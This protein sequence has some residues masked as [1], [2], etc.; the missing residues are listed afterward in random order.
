MYRNVDGQKIVKMKRSDGSS[1]RL[2]LPKK[3]SDESRVDYQDWDALNGAEKNH[4][5]NCITNFAYFFQHIFYP[6][7]CRGQGKNVP[8]EIFPYIKELCDDI[9]NAMHPL[10]VAYELEKSVASKW[11]IC[12][13]MPTRSMKSTVLCAAFPLWVLGCNNDLRVIIATA[14]QGLGERYVRS[15]KEYITTNTAF[16]DVFGLLHNEKSS[17][18]WAADAIEIDGRRRTVDPSMAVFGIES[19]I[20]GYGCDILVSDDAQTENNSQTVDAR[21]K[22]WNWFTSAAK[23]RLESEARLLA[24]I[25]TRHNGGDFAGMVKEGGT[26]STA[27]DYKE[28]AAIE[29]ISMWP[30]KAEDLKDPNGPL[31]VENLIDPEMWESHLLC[32]TVLPLQA[33]LEEWADPGAR[34]S[35]A[36]TRLNLVQDPSTKWFPLSMLQN[37]ARADGGFRDDGSIRPKLRS[38]SVEI[39]I[40]QPGMDIFEEYD[41]AGINITKR[42]ISIDPA[43]TVAKRGTDPDYTVMQLWGMDEHTGLRIL[44]DMLRFRTSSPLV[45][46]QKLKRFIDAYQPHRVIFESN[47]LARWVGTE[48]QQSLGH[49]IKL[50]QKGKDHASKLE[51]FKDLIESG[52]FFYCWSGS[53]AIEKMK[54]FEQELD[55]YPYGSHDDTIDCAVQ[56]QEELQVKMFREM[57]VGIPAAPSQRNNMYQFSPPTPTKTEVSEKLKTD[58][59]DLTTMLGE[60]M[61][62]VGQSI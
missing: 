57:K 62:R 43:T 13:V 10:L 14:S 4:V 42:V 45:F 18:K 8:D 2:V 5:V 37:N 41:K 32:P 24:I 36:L 1:L 12:R 27:W 50:Y 21:A 60:V 9:Q 52:L 61:R 47:G 26:S 11:Q 48:I 59:A 58:I 39:G 16:I 3:W 20:E 34:A 56:A 15:M 31:T 54:P 55:A 17:A 40:P 38:W 6:F 28:R 49:P 23:S 30:P 22:Q 19:S 44:L 29:P 25:Q 53:K 33:L 51:A 35:F 46:K 7:Y